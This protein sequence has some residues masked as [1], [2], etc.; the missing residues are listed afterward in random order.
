MKEGRDQKE[1]LKKSNNESQVRTPSPSQPCAR[2][3]AAVAAQQE[4]TTYSYQLEVTDAAIVFFFQV[5]FDF[6]GR[7]KGEEQITKLSSAFRLDAAQVAEQLRSQSRK[8]CE[9]NKC[10]RSVPV[11][12][13][14][15]AGVP[16]LEENKS[17]RSSQHRERAGR[18]EAGEL[19]GG[20]ID[21][22]GASKHSYRWMFGVM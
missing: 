12:L 15:D 22:R 18:K 9:T 20:R 8:H 14:E 19:L 11:V 7:L 5:A 13:P 21:F 4:V 6:V 3:K 16:Q 17:R 1:A 2:L 10:P